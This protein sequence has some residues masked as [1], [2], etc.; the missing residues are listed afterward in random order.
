MRLLHNGI[1]FLQN[2]T[3]PISMLKTEYKRGRSSASSFD[4]A[5][6]CPS[7]VISTPTNLLVEGKSCLPQF[8]SDLMVL[9]NFNHADEVI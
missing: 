8:D 1:P 3:N 5:G 7:F 6:E 4:W 2:P 9:E